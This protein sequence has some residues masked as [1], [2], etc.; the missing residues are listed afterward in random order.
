MVEAKKQNKHIKFIEYTGRYPNLCR[1]NLILE[2]DGKIVV[3]EYLG[4]YDDKPTNFWESGGSVTFGSNFSEKVTKGPWTVD[5]E[6]LPEEYRK[7]ADEIEQV[8]NDNVPHG[9][10]GGCV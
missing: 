6:K 1:G 3:F 7:Y 2:I 10:C 4:D 9:C 5:V 8:F